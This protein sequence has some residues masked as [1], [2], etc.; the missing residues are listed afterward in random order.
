ME[1]EIKLVKAA[2]KA[3]GEFA[4]RK[5]DPLTALG[6]RTFSAFLTPKTLGN[7]LRCSRHYGTSITG[8]FDCFRNGHRSIDGYFNRTAK[9]HSSVVVS[10]LFGDSLTDVTFIL[11]HSFPKRFLPHF[12]SAAFHNIF[13]DFN[14]KN[15]NCSPLSR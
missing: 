8:F 4:S 15:I 14:W 3:V 5:L 9:C 2:K 1:Y 10:P 6:R 13:I 12:R 11:S 7:D